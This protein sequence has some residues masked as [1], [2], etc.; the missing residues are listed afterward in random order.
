MA[1]RTQAAAPRCLMVLLAGAL[2]APAQDFR[3]DVRHDHP[4]KSGPGVLRLTVDGVSFV[5]TTRKEHARSWVYRDIQQLEVSPG[6]IRVLT[7]EDRKWR[8]GADR[9]ETY[10]IASDQPVDAVYAFLKTRLDQRLVAAL[11]DSSAPAVWQLPVKLL[12]RIRGSEGALL[13]MRD[14][15][16][17][18]TDAPGQSR[19]WRFED[20]DNISTS[21]PFQLTVT[22]FERARFHYGSRK[23]FNFQLKQ[24]LEEGRYNELWRAVNRGKGLEAAGR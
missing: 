1:F 7:Y 3:F 17:Y 15:I 18:Q 13:V 5:E 22:T 4:R 9:E 14:R 16:V 11:A 21:G 12:G 2:V 10:L 6:R 8:I 24:V 20:I 19:T 23:G